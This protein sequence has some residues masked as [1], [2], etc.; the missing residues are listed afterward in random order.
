[1]SWQ[2]WMINL[3][4]RCAYKDNDEGI[5]EVEDQICPDQSKYT[6]VNGAS[7]SWAEYLLKLKQYSEFSNEN[8]RAVEDFDDVVDLQRD[9]VIASSNK[10]CHACVLGAYQK[11]VGEFGQADVPLMASF[12]QVSRMDLEAVIGHEGS[13]V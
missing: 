13:L 5:N 1:M 8:K 4:P 6:P 2:L 12:T 7:P 9:S 11:Q 3:R 10:R